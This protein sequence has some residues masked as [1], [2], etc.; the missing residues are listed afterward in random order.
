MNR[1]STDFQSSETTLCDAIMV[2]KGHQTFVK[3]H[4]MYT[5]SDRKTNYRLWVLMICQCRFITVTNVP[6][7]WGM[8]IMPE[9]L[10]VIGQEVCEK[11]LYLP[12]RSSVYSKN[13]VYFSKLFQ[14]SHKTWRVKCTENNLH[15]LQFTTMIDL[16]IPN[17]I[18]LDSFAYK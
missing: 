3:T 6:L 12:L 15:H 2:D 5:K 7:W 9:A 8:L 1:W 10:H 18:P 14:S 17:T 16:G 11:S 4:R 13:T